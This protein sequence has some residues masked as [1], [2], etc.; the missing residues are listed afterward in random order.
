MKN[1]ETHCDNKQQ[2]LIPVS[3]WN[4]YHEWPTTAGLRYLIFNCEKNGFESVIRRIGRRVLL[5]EPDFF[6]WVEKRNGLQG[7]K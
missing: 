1:Y 7:G 2:R 6:D 4:K 3:L 5:S